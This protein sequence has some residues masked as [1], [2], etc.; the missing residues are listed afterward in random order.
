MGNRI[1]DNIPEWQLKY[2]SYFT[3]LINVEDYKIKERDFYSYLWYSVM[4]MKKEVL[5]PNQTSPGIKLKGKK[6]KGGN[7]PPKNKIGSSNKKRSV[8][9]KASLRKNTWNGSFYWL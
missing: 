3:D 5:I 6:S 7:Q 4:N 9:F 1:S 8:L 2:F